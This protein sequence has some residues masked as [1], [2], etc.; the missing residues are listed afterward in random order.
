MEILRDFKFK[1]DKQHVLNVVATY[2]P[3]G[4]REDRGRIYDNLIE[5]LKDS[6]NP[7]GFFKIDE[8]IEEYN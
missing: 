2:L 7:I 6:T 1:L 4:D 8:K 3:I 5:V